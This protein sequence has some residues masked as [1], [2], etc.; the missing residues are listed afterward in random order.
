MKVKTLLLFC[1][2]YSS[3]CAQNRLDSASYINYYQSIVKMLAN[4]SMMGRE[5]SSIYED[6]AA[7][8]IVNEFKKNKNFKPVIQPFNYISPDSLKEKKSKNVYC[9]INNHA[10]STVLIGAHYEHIGLGGKLSYSLNKK[11]EIHNGADDNASG[12]ALMLGLA[13]SFR[14]WQNKKYN[15]IFVAYS[16]HEI[17]L[18]GSA[19]FYAFVEDK[20]PSICNVINFDMVGRMD[21]KA[22]VINVYG[23]G[24]ANSKTK[25]YLDSLSSL[26][27]KVYTENGTKINDTD[28]RAFVNHNIKCLSFTTG[29]HNDYHKTSDD[30]DKINYYGIFQMQQLVENL[31]RNSLLKLQ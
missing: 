10:D 31:F 11:N 9:F 5:V 14:Q 13:R 20:F 18:Y 24:N 26:T 28:C 6:K 4:D 23:L 12:V 17:G 7:K 25:Q 15:Y 2:V 30:E 21:E 27:R 19:A 8:F 1:I 22:P 3:S 16:A 29:T